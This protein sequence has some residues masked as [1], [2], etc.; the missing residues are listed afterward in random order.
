M[1]YLVSGS[2]NS[3]LSRQTSTRNEHMPTR[4]IRT[5]MNVQSKDHI[6]QKEPKETNRLK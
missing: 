4:N 1:E 2:R 3:P 6:D 5:R